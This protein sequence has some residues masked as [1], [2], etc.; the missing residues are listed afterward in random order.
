MRNAPCYPE[1]ACTYPEN[2]YGRCPLDRAQLKRLSALTKTDLNNQELSAHVSFTR[3]EKSFCLTRFSSTDDPDY[4]EALAIIQAGQA[5]LRERP[6]ADMTGFR[7]LGLD[8][9]R[10]AKYQFRDQKAKTLLKGTV[11]QQP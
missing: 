7:L 1:Y 5:M 4:Q 9:E 8:A 3:P 10:E 6:R 11:D 2:R